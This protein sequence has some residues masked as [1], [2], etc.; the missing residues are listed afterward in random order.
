MAKPAI[1]SIGKRRKAIARAIIKPGKGMIRINGKRIDVYEPKLA[2]DRIMEP[3]LLLADEFKERVSGVCCLAP[4]LFYD[5]WNTPWARFIL[6]L[7]YFT[8]LRHFFY[9]KEESDF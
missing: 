2:R 7:G 1:I 4:T 3:V 5:G 8:P 9:F 6:P